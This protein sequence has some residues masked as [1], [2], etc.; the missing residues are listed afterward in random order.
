MTNTKKLQG[1]GLMGMYLESSRYPPEN[2]GVL[3]QK[4]KFAFLWSD[5]P[6]GFYFW[7]YIY[8]CLFLLEE[9]EKNETK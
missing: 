9:E 1:M 7:N 2:K 3:S 8:K 5:S 6:E 4:I